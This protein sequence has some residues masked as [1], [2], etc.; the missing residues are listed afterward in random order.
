LLQSFDGTQARALPIEFTE[1]DDKNGYIFFVLE[2]G[3]V[4]NPLYRTGARL[5][6]LAIT[7]GFDTIYAQATK[8]T[9][10]LP[11][12]NPYSTFRLS[13]NSPA[14]RVALQDQQKLEAFLEVTINVLADQ[15][16]FWQ[17]M[18]LL[19]EACTIYP[20]ALV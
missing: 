9:N 20:T 12:T 17:R 5:A 2:T 14:L 16:L 19:R 6:A 4:N 11:T 13:V 18:T 10:V 8:I 3:D 15:W 7:D 1:G